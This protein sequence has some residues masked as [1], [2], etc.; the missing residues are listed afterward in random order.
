MLPVEP[1]QPFPVYPVLTDLGINQRCDARFRLWVWCRVLS[2]CG[3]GG[4][5]EYKEYGWSQEK[6]LLGLLRG[7]YL[8]KID[9]F[10]GPKPV[11]TVF[12]A[13]STC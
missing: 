10:S 13:F 11:N 1:I 7:D 8:R 4:E 5:N 2:A 6:L 3:A 9:L 12:C